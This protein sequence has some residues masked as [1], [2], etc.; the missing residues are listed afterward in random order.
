MKKEEKMFVVY[1]DGK[2]D[3]V[4]T[5]TSLDE[6]KYDL[7]YDEATDGEISEEEKK[8]Y[9]FRELPKM[10]SQPL[11]EA[12]VEAINEINWT[13]K[14]ACDEIS[15][16]IGGEWNESDFRDWFDEYIYEARACFLNKAMEAF[17]NTEMY[18]N[19]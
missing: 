15:P 11:K 9:T 2:R 8:R 13:Y 10:D 17:K 12:M 19:Y 14:D 6:V 3:C 1:K 18:K 7:F 5:E 16:T 4:Y